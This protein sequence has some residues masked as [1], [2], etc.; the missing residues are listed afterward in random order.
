[1]R[2][3]LLLLFS[4]NSVCLAQ[5]NQKKVTFQKEKPVIIIGLVIDQMRWDYLYR[6]QDRYGKGGFKRLLQKGFSF[7]NTFIPYTPAVTAAGHTSIY[8]GSVPALHGIVGNDWVERKTGERMY[9]TQDRNVIGVGGTGSQGQMSPQNLLA[10]TI[11]DELRLS[12]NFKSRVFGIALKDRG[13]IVAAGRSSNAAYW[14]DD[15]GGQWITSTWYMNALPA[16]V[17]NF[18]AQKKPDAMMRNDWNLLYNANTYTQSTADDVPYEKTLQYEKNITFPHSYKEMIGKNYYDFRVSPYG[19]TYTLDFATA[20]L[21]NEKLGTN[22]YIDMLCISLSST[23]YIGHRFGPNSIEIEDTYLRLDR[24]L[25]KFI[26]NLDAT[27]GNGN[28]LLFLSADHG[29]PPVPAFMQAHKMSAGTLNAYFGIRDSLN[30]LALQKFGVDGLVS[31]VL[32]YQVFLNHK[33]ISENNL[34]IK[35]IKEFFVYYLQSRPEIRAVVDFENF[36]DVLLPEA[37]KESIANGYYQGRSG[38]LQLIYKPNYTDVAAIGTEHGTIYPY[39]THI[40]LIFYGWNVK[41]GNTYR[42]TFMTDIA[43][44]IAAMLRIQMPNASVGNVLPEIVK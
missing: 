41:P 32:E 17:N 4:I 19:N 21:A 39:D 22:G 40:P 11:G 34:S 12:N 38:D 27:Y 7:N 9:C 13:G 23:D 35:A 18:N 1:M 20:L 8:T 10:T 5:S 31:Y 43:P 24:D 37:I 14:F 28:Y 15:A 33:K 25:E 44:T 36:S 6:Y 30:K 42:K 16:W 3:L 29:A 2:F 26:N